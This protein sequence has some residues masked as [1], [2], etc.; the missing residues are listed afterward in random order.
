[1]TAKKRAIPELPVSKDLLTALSILDAAPLPV[2]VFDTDETIY[3]INSAAEQTLG[4]TKLEATGG[5]FTSLILAA[6]VQNSFCVAL[7]RV[8]GSTDKTEGGNMFECMLVKKDGRQLPFDAKLVRMTVDDC[9]WLI[10]YALDL[11]D[12]Q[13]QQEALIE[14]TNTVRQAHE[15]Q[16]TILSGVSHTLRNPLNA[17]FG[18]AQLLEAQTLSEN[19]KEMVS[20]ILQSCQQLSGHIEDLLSLSEMRSGASQANY[21]AI[22]VRDEVQAFVFQCAR[23]LGR[24]AQF[25]ID[26]NVPDVVLGDWQKIKL[27]LKQVIAAIVNEESSP[28]VQLHCRLDQQQD[29]T[30]LLEFAFLLPARKDKDKRVALSLFA[31]RSSQD[32]QKED[33]AAIISRSLLA[34]MGGWLWQELGDKGEVLLKFNLKVKRSQFADLGSTIPGF[35]RGK[36][37]LLLSESPQDASLISNILSQWSIDTLCLRSSEQVLNF[38]PSYLGLKHTS[39]ILSTPE[40]MPALIEKIELTPQLNYL[41]ELPVIILNG[42]SD[43][44]DLLS[45]NSDFSQIVIAHRSAASLLS[46][47]RKS[48]KTTDCMVCEN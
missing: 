44:N 21:D 45:K 19:Q 8:L 42:S 37:C 11:T 3:H 10:L 22:S 34:V 23:N 4:W 18:M 2:F 7:K 5:N 35:F 26:E 31:D 24:K 43:D 28:P 46:S 15:L 13:K 6:P 39:C 29:D 30:G 47:L 36:L 14:A 9:T 27:V 32:G 40:L 41:K 1:M 25:T 48:L 38:S 17:I 33:L 12:R 16:E 20:T